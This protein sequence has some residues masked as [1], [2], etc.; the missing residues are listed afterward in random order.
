M[1]PLS[2]L[3]Y[4][5]ADPPCVPFTPAPLRKADS[6]RPQKSQH[7]AKVLA[8]EKTL[9][10][11]RSPPERRRRPHPEWLRPQ[12]SPAWHQTRLQSVSTAKGELVVC[13]PFIC[14]TPLQIAFLHIIDS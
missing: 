2:S 11:H 12:V 7:P 14:P 10:L 3:P 4:P 6:R 5:V 13:L 8:K 9:Q 1:D